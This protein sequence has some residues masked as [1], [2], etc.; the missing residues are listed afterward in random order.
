MRV[1]HGTAIEGVDVDPQ[2]RC[3]HWHGETD[4]VAIK[5]KCC[6]RWFSCFECHAAVACD[7]SPEVWPRGEFDE[8][9]VLCGACGHR[10][11]INEYLACASTCPHCKARF[12]P[13][14]AN[15]YHLYF[16]R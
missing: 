16:E 11:T 13:G 2:T 14:C 4:I 5:F 7:H 15:H 6:G 1:V 10:L 8:P 9:A 12:N 3:G